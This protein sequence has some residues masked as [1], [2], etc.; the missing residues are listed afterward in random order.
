MHP[1]MHARARAGGCATT[2]RTFRNDGKGKKSLRASISGGELRPVPR[3]IIVTERR[4]ICINK[5]DNDRSRRLRGDRSWTGPSY[6]D[7]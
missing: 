2:E 5:R 6:I 1:Q 3:G 7:N 4:L